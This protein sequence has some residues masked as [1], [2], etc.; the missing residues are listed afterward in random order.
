[1]AFRHCLSCRGVMKLWPIED[2]HIA[3]WR[4][5]SCSAELLE[6]LRYRSEAQHDHPK[7][8]I[9]HPPADLQVHIG[10]DWP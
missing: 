7:R 3:W 10:E 4:C 6:D 8:Q 1:M 9:K 5:T 2:E